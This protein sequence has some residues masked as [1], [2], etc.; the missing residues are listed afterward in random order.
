MAW[1]DIGKYD[2]L[3]AASTYIKTLEN[4]QGLKIG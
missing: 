3:H 1:F 4:R 2:S